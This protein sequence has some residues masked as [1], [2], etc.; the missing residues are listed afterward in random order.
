MRWRN[1]WPTCSTPL[2]QHGPTRPR[3]T[4]FTSTARA[5]RCLQKQRAIWY[6]LAPAHDAQYWAH[7][8]KG[9][10]IFAKADDVNPRSLQSHC[11]KGL[12]GDPT[13]PEGANLNEHAHARYK[14]AMKLL[15]KAGPADKRRLRANKYSRSS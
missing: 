4:G 15:A 7:V 3:G 6:V 12:K 9:M 5:C 13:I 1:P 8:T 2:K 14:Q 10:P 11:V